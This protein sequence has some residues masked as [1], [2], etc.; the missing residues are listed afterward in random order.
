MNLIMNQVI[1]EVEVNKLLDFNQKFDITLLDQ[2]V[3]FMYQG[4]GPQVIYVF[5]YFF[6]FLH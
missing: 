2:V 6:D 4:H 5:L 1:N 3:N